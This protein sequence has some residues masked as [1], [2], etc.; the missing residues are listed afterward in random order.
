MDLSIDTDQPEAIDLAEA[1]AEETPIKDVSDRHW[2]I[3]GHPRITAHYI[4]L[5]F[6]RLPSCPSILAHDPLLEQTSSDRIY[7]DWIATPEAK[8]YLRALELREASAA[9][10]SK[11]LEAIAQTRES[12]GESPTAGAL[13]SKLIGEH[14]QAGELQKAYDQAVRNAHTKA[15]EKMQQM[16]T[17]RGLEAMK[18][19][20]ARKH[21][22]L[23][24][25]ELEIASVLTEL[26]RLSALRGRCDAIAPTH[27]IPPP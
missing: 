6:R 13:F 19:I 15:V 21:A 7:A 9:A 12:L 27:M 20:T 3:T 14:A 22:L 16:A 2:T 8:G 10:D 17:G 24:A 26:A 5:A 1:E 11:R 4:E 25:L 23:D 18:T